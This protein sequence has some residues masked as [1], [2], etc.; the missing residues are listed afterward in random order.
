MESRGEFEIKLGAHHVARASGGDDGRGV[1]DVRV[2]YLAVVGAAS[3]RAPNACSSSVPGHGLHRTREY[4]LVCLCEGAYDHL[5]ACA[6]GGVHGACLEATAP[7][8]G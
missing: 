6:N 5:T 1:G 2:V 3:D 8:G 7:C 4:E